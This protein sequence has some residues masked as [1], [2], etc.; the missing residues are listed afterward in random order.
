MVTEKFVM[1]FLASAARQRKVV[2]N[3]QIT[4][5]DFDPVIQKLEADGK[6]TIFKSGVIRRYGIP[7]RINLNRHRCHFIRPLGLLTRNAF[8]G[9]K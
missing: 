8:P 4:G 7:T 1:D 9:R 5:Y 6:V 2:L 3:W